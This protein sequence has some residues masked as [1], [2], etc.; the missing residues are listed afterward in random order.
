MAAG[1]SG[2][3]V[4]GPEFEAD[5]WSPAQNLSRTEVRSGGGSAGRSIGLRAR[6]GSFD[7]EMNCRGDPETLWYHLPPQPCVE[8]TG[9]DGVEL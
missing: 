7:A 9:G 3:R 5:S 1:V 8:I 6:N 4:Q 2:I